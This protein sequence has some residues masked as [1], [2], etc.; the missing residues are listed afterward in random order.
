MSE[1]GGFQS[2]SPSRSDLTASRGTPREQ[3][4]V[5]DWGQISSVRVNTTLRNNTDSSNADSSLKK[6]TP[7]GINS[8]FSGFHREEF[9]VHE[10]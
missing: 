8:G 4:P 1:A 7:E 6:S 10:D 9:L 3:S 5:L 2:R